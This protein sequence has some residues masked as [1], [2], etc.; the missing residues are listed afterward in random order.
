[1]GGVKVKG[2][3]KAASGLASCLFTTPKSA[4]GKT[5]AG[6]VSFRAGGQPFTKRFSVRLG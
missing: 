4:K 1:M 2:G 6:S 3:A 5:L